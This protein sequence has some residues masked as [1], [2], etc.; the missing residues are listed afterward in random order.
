D[1]DPPKSP[2]TWVAQRYYKAV[3]L[4][5]SQTSGPRLDPPHAEPW[6]ANENMPALLPKASSPSPSPPG[7]QALPPKTQAPKASPIKTQVLADQFD[8]PGELFRRSKAG[9]R[10]RC[11]LPHKGQ[12][13]STG[14]GRKAKHICNVVSGSPSRLFQFRAVPFA[15]RRSHRARI[16]PRA[17]IRVDLSSGNVDELSLLHQLEHQHPRQA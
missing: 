4:M 11:I 8:T 10:R 1:P 14:R 7:T 5:K 9:N 6:M 16:H 13:Q 3:D 17:D 12:A 2:R 15:V